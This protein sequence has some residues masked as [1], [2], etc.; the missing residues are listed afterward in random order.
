MIA[1]RRAPVCAPGAVERIV[2]AAVGALIA[3]FALSTLHDPPLAVAAALGAAVLITGAV[4][5][6]C[7]ASLL[8]RASA[9]AS[10]AEQNALGIPEAR[11]PLD[12]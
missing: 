10:G 4:R 8:A 5:G 9:H 7:P 2:Q 6:W 1:R 11:Q 3:A 12:P